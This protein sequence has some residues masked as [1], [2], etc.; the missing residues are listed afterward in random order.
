MASARRGN[1]SGEESR[2]SF[3]RRLI[4]A[5]LVITVSLGCVGG[6]TALRILDPF[7]LRNARETSFDLLQRLHPRTYIETP[8]KIVDIDERSLEA[9]GQWPWPRDMLAE[10]IDRLHA[11]GASTVAFDVI[12]SEPDRL[13][14][15]RLAADPRMR[16]ALGLPE[17]AAAPDLPDNDQILADAMKRGYVVIGFGVTSVLDTLPPVKAGFAYT[18][19]DPARYVTPMLGGAKV[20]PELAEAAAGIGSLNLSEDLSLGVV[21]STPLVWTDGKRLYPSLSMEA[22][23]IAQD[24]R[25]FVVHADPDT[26]GVQSIRIG[27]FEVPTE[28]TGELNLYYTKPRADRYISA[29]DLFDNEKLQAM[30]PDL[31]GRIILV[32]TSAIGLHDIRKT[33]LGDSVPGVEIH[34]QAMEQIINEQFLLRHDWTRG[35]E[36]LALVVASA[37]ILATTFY[38]G[39]R[40][41]LLFGG[42]VA[43]AVAVGSW[44]AFRRFG[45]LIDPS[46]PLGG[47]I[48]VWFVST[49]FRYL[50]SDREK[51]EIRGAFSHYV[52]PSV[53]RQIERNHRSVRLGGEN[54]ELTVMFTDVR[55]FTKLS[56]RI[57]PEQVV[58]FL[59]K[60]LGRL[61]SEISRE[62][63][64]IDK[65]IG[66]SVMAFWN[67]PLRQE[68]H[69]RR[70]CKAALGM[71]AAVEEMNA[72]Q[73]FGL[74]EEIAR[75]EPVEI[76][77]GINTGPA[78]VGNVG[79]SDRFNYS[80]IGD[81]VNVAARAESACKELGYDLVVT[82]ST[83]ELA[84]EF[85]FVSA[86]MVH[87][88][89]K[90]EPVAMV[91]LVGGPEVRLS[92][93]FSEFTRRYR[94][95]ID[96]LRDGRRQDAADVL[97]DCRSLAAAV[98]PRLLRYLDKVPSRVNDFR[99]EHNPRIG[100]VS[101]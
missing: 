82:R 12:F 17:G 52:A 100:L 67:A 38:S 43:A 22:L 16:Q 10:M 92:P 44:D 41:S 58:T 23:G 69:A 20:L 88:K 57:E 73:A 21:R 80:A 98:D 97:V 59:N 7:V 62:A 99:P 47:S 29:V 11:A 9:F 27:A 45:V 19:E 26:G 54:C 56:E 1:G 18:G 93:Q 8:V 51:R 68:D 101:G 64:V 78:C 2:G 6:L 76:G 70:A 79:S 37:I 95:L 50:L 42:I 34:A 31:E 81:A 14:P 33:A 85:A 39:A 94:L 5:F 28:P 35:L 83:A 63:G 48:G 89:G 30:V 25:T 40:L 53:L 72:K 75:G 77:V 66:D 4:P 24:A 61:G 49:V 46:F 3:W 91:L 32:G 65:F 60:L 36:V 96:A 87:L 84:T 55:N 86:G 13:S 90:A 15:S 74:P 71:R